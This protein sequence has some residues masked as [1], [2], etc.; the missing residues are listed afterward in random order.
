VLL[1]RYTKQTG[2]TAST[3][4]LKKA[5]NYWTEYARTRRVSPAQEEEH[6]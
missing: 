4:E 3:R 2:Q 5:F 6:E 1:H